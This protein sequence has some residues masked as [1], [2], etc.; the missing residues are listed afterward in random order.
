MYCT[1]HSSNS[2]LELQDFFISEQS[3]EI[4]IVLAGAGRRPRGEY[5]RPAR[6]GRMRRQLSCCE[7]YSL[8]FARELMIFSATDFGISV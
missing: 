1:C 6:V 7:N 3:S 8:P 4:K 5:P 2:I